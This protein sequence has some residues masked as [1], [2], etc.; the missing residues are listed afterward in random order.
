V[1][2]AE[3][4]NLERILAFW[5]ASEEVQSEEEKREEIY[6]WISHALAWLLPILKQI[7]QQ[8]PVRVHGK[9]GAV[10]RKHMGYGH[11]AADLC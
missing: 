9:N 8:F 1:Q 2:Q 5:E 4:L 6:G 11:I 10:I 3:K 7:L